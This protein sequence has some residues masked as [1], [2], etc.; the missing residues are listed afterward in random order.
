MKSS[1]KHSEYKDACAMDGK[2]FGYVFSHYERLRI[3]LG[4]L[5][6]CVINKISH[7]QLCCVRGLVR[8]RARVGTLCYI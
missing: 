5:Q 6:I 7:L 1:L 4:I 3:K 2:L 8:A